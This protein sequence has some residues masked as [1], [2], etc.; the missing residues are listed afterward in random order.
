MKRIPEKFFKDIFGFQKRVSVI[1]FNQNFQLLK[2]IESIGNNAFYELNNLE[3]LRLYSQSLSHIPSNAFAFRN[4][5]NV[6]LIIFLN[7]NDLISSSF[8]IG[9]FT[10]AKR[11]LGLFLDRNKIT[12]FDEN[13]FSPFL[14]LSPQNSMDLQN[15]PIN[16]SD[17]RNYW[18][19]KEK[20]N[21]ESKVSNAQ[22]GGGEGKSIFDPRVIDFVHCEGF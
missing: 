16:C 11:P 18:M 3:H 4:S 9:A 20:R 17:C 8:S 22:C 12:Y 19:I 2:K 5:S 6:K 7:Y 1:S 15:N 14:S 21:I 10:N 13:I